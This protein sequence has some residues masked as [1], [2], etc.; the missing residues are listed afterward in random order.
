MRAKARPPALAWRWGAPRL[1][2]AAVRIDGESI[3]SPIVRASL[4]ARVA[5]RPGGGWYYE[6][7]ATRDGLRV[8]RAEGPATGG[9]HGVLESL[10]E[11]IEEG[12]E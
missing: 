12:A 1:D 10:Q 4:V 8:A 9:I 11:Q 2:G 3:G 7:E 6:G 5:D